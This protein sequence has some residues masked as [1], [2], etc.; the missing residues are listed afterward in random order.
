MKKAIESDRIFFPFDDS[1]H[2]TRQQQER[3]KRSVE[4]DLK[5]K[6]TLS[7]GYSGKIIGTTGNTY[8]VTL[9]NCSCQDFKR[10]NLPCKHMYFLAENTLRCNVW[11]D[12]K[13]DEY[14]IEKISIKK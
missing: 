3:I 8:L 7:N 11:R 13:T 12:E 9:K 4:H 1:I 6:T 2:K 5:I 14:C 10:R